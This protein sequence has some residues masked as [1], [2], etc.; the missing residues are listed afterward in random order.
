MPKW[1]IYESRES[2]ARWAAAVYYPEDAGHPDLPPFVPARK[3][4]VEVNDGGGYHAFDASAE[5]GW[6][7]YR[8]VELRDYEGLDDE[9]V[10]FQERVPKNRE[11]FACGWIAPNGDT[12]SCGAKAHRAAADAI[13]DA[14]YPGDRPGGE[15]CLEERGWIRLADAGSWTNEFDDGVFWDLSNVP[16]KQQL[17]RLLDL[18]RYTPK[19]E[20]NVEMSLARRARGGKERAWL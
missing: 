14:L 12:Y 11:K 8:L 4:P 15:R 17:D 18:G 13:A 2:G 1:A 16:T 6:R 20:E 3:L 5:E 10:A 19:V 9:V 7:G